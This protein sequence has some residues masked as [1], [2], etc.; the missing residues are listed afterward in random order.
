MS[1]KY[2]KHLYTKTLFIGNS[3]LTGYVVCV[4]F[5]LNCTPVQKGGG[6]EVGFV[7]DVAKTSQEE[8]AASSS[9][10]IPSLLQMEADSRGFSQSPG[11]SRSWDVCQPRGWA[12]VKEEP[13]L[14]PCPGVSRPGSHVAPLVS[15]HPRL[16]TAM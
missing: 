10:K 8:E 12:G 4:C 9:S 1:H 13:F 14:A 7:L 5:F 6:A 3:D 11:W 2:L 15:F 16:T